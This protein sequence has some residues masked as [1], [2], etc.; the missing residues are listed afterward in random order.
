MQWMRDMFKKRPK[1]VHAKTLIGSNN[2][3]YGVHCPEIFKDALTLS[4]FCFLKAIGHGYASTVFEVDYMPPSKTSSIPSTNA[5]Y[6]CVLKIVMKSR[7]SSNEYRRMCREISIHSS[8]SHRHILTFFACFEDE[9]AFYIILEHASDGDLLTYLSKLPQHRMSTSRYRTFVLQ[10]LLLAMSYLHQL[11]IIHR[12][13]KPENIL[14]DRMGRIRLCDFGLSIKTFQEKPRSIVG[15]LDYMAPELLEG[16]TVSLYLSSLS[17]RLDVWSIGVLTYECITGKSPF[18]G[19][20]DKEV[21]QRIKNVSYDETLVTD[22]LVLDFI[23]QCLQKDPALRPT[24]QQLL[25]HSL[26]IVTSNSAKEVTNIRRSFSY[27]E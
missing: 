7:L 25:H 26:F 22:P 16:D 5:P 9:N 10:P 2:Y 27:P 1:R 19:K 20:T 11:G 6:L 21:I 18:R 15:T 14:I 4:D 8:I 24:V 23:K 12:D 13:I 17:D 3:T